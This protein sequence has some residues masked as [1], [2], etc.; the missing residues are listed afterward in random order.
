M[1][2]HIQSLLF[3]TTKRATMRSYYHS[4]I[5]LENRFKRSILTDEPTITVLS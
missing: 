1:T 4:R 3:E 5:R 2:T